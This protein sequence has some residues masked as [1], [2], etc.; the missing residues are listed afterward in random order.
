MLKGYVNDFLK[1]RSLNKKVR[2]AK[3]DREVKTQSTKYTDLGLSAEDAEYLARKDVRGKK[4][5]EKIHNA[6][7]SLSA[8]LSTGSPEQTK[9]K[10][11]QKDDNSKQLSTEEKLRNALEW[12]Y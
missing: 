3:E 9:S 12:K 2:D 4:R 10:S 7:N 1:E 11:D 5:K 6:F 8:G